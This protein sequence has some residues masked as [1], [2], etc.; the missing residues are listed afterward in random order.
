MKQEKGKEEEGMKR[1]IAHDVSSQLL[2]KTVLYLCAPPH[3]SRVTIWNLSDVRVH[4]YCV[5]TL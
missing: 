1:G 5:K 2:N 4:K 3:E